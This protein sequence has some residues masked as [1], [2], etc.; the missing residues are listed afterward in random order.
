MLD[1]KLAEI[2]ET[3]PELETGEYTEEQLYLIR[4]YES[5]RLLSTALENARYAF[6]FIDA[7]MYVHGLN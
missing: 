1:L 6:E 5:H 2:Y 7:Y 4:L 3:F